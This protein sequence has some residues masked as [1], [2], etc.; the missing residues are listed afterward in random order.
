M[1][2]WR[3]IADY[4]E[5]AKDDG[6]VTARERLEL[7]VKQNKANRRIANEANDGQHR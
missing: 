4:E 3:N 6:R 5:R 1:N 2:S 7:Q